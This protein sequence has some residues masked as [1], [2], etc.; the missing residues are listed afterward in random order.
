[1]D[2]EAIERE[3]QRVAQQLID[4][5]YQE[6]DHWRR[7][8]SPGTRWFQKRLRHA[9]VV[10]CSISISTIVGRPEVYLVIESQITLDDNLAMNIEIFHLDHERIREQVRQLE[11]LIEGLAL[12]IGIHD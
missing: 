4:M 12:A 9:D 3:K 10:G 6:Y 8:E 2:L 1:M 11:R 7:H 5:G